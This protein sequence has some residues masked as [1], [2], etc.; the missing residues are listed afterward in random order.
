MTI[1]H[2]QPSDGSH[3][4]RDDAHAP[5]D[6]AELSAGELE[7]LVLEHVSRPN[8]QPVKPRVIAKQLGLP[9]DRMTALR[10][11]L[12]RLVRRGQICYGQKHLVRP[13][14]DPVE[15]IQ[16]AGRIT[17]RFQRSSEGYGFVRPVTPEE[18]EAEAQGEPSPAEGEAN[19]EEAPG[20]ERTARRRRETDTQE[21]TDIFIPAGATLDA[22]NGD[23]V[24]VEIRRGRR[25]GP[26][27]WGPRGEIL[28]VLERRTHRF[29]GT[30]FHSGGVAFV[31]VDGT[32]FADRVPIGDVGDQRIKPGDKILVEMV[33]FPSPTDEGR[34]AIIEV[35]GEPGKP[36]VATRV[37][38]REF[39][40]PEDFDELVLDNARQQAGKFK[41]EVG[42]DRTDMTDRTVVTIDPIDARDFDDAISLEQ[43]SDGRWLLDVHIAD[44]AH[45]VPHKS[46]LDVEARARST[47]VYLP[48]RVIPM[49]PETISNALASLQPGEVRYTKTA[50]IQLLPTGEI[51]GVDVRRTAIRSTQRLTYEEVDAFIEDPTTGRRIWS[52]EV[53][54]LLERMRELAQLLRANRK[55]RGML[56]LHM[57]D[58]RVTLDRSGS[59]CGAAVQPQT[60]SRRMIEEFMVAANEAV[61]QWLDEHKANYLR[62]IHLP[63]LPR[64]M[65]QLTEFV[66]QLGLSAGNLQNRFELQELLEDV[67][68]RPERHAVNFATLRAM[69]RAVYGPETEG[70]FALASRQY[71]HFTSPIRRYP[72]LVAHRIID[73][74]LD[75]KPTPHE[76]N[77]ARLGEHCSVQERR[78]E[79]AERSLTKLLLLHYLED[80]QGE[81]MDAVITGVKRFGLFAQGTKLP[82]EGFIPIGMLNDDHYHFD[83]ASHSL[84]GYKDGNAFRL[85]DRVRV[86]VMRVDT[87]RRTLDFRLVSRSGKKGKGKSKGKKGAYG[88]KR[89]RR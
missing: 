23:L 35:L 52:E 61:A 72:D 87:D 65:R 16:R 40:L 42:P 86:A 13:V 62:R 30:F 50:Q 77:L 8:Y 79:E 33:R 1:P 34:A 81:E 32:V 47:S 43:S 44:V 85:G 45:F 49:L 76:E 11:A 53:C 73:A 54:A 17:G 67:F 78:A 39:N 51:V 4:E 22:A 15:V 12:K 70:H 84:T 82:A 69:Q 74:I 31:R 46:A 27:D 2:N 28:E 36:G 80:R 68:N 83:R 59:V 41:A 6:P 55:D 88:K 48:D 18:I 60:E 56:E 9:R 75:G 26:K 7:R 66:R 19:A 89:N 25:H 24:L 71:L 5:I 14:T 38:M 10:R 37:I 20:S 64:K 21:S 57:P 58:V 63:P 29:V 3:G